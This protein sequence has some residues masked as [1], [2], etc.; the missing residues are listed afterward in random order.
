MAITGVS[1]IWGR[2]RIPATILVTILTLTGSSEAAEANS[3]GMYALSPAGSLV[4][5]TIS[6][7]ATLLPIRREGRFKQFA[8]EVSYD[9]ARPDNTRVDPTVYTAS[10]DMNN[11]GHDELLR[12]DNFFDVD[13][14]P[15]MHF[16]GAVAGAKPDGTLTVAGDL[17][18]RGIVKRISAPVTFRPAGANPA[19]FETTFQIDRT[20]FGLNGVPTWG[21][22]K[23][24]IA[25]KV[26]IHIAIA[27]AGNARTATH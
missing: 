24:S 16:T 27:T 13:H 8:G 26:Q 11:T 17:T 2:L 22:F 14:F 1:G 19:V 6:G 23:V 3:P 25:K 9:P 7:R 18:I 15:T 20:D 5:F 21:G 12:S 10:I 4:S